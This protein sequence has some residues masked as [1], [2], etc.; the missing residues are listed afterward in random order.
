VG[1][2][3]ANI[4]HQWRQPLNII[5][6][7]TA[8]METSILFGGEINKDDIRQVSEEINRQSQYLSDTIDDFRNYFNSDTERMAPFNLKD[9][10]TKV[11]ELTKDSFNNYFIES[12]I[13]VY[14]CAI[15]HNESLFMQALLNI[16][17]NARDA[18]IQS[19]TGPR[20]FFVNLRCNGDNAVISIKDS[21]GGIDN[22]VMPRIFE[23]YYT[24]KHLSQGTGLGLYI[25]YEIVTK[26][27]NGTLEVYNRSYQYK[28]RHLKGAEFI[29][30]IP[31]AS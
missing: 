7:N 5:S 26:H 8:K 24:T 27:L 20:Y 22:E 2:M 1:E 15:T 4:A 16:Y 30:T 31:R 10:I 9:A 11:T 17:N 25:T 18:I 13:T 19:G 28:G 3:L 12:V 23:P 29:I 6:L 14:D 21:G